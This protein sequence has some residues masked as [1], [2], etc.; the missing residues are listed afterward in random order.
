MPV[1]ASRYV[2]AIAATLL[3]F[4]AHADDA[5]QWSGFALLRAA[6]DSQARPLETEKLS[7]Q[8]QLGV[9]WW[10]TPAF[11]AHVHLVARNDAGSLRGSVGVAEAYVELNVH[12]G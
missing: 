8:M 9:D 1:A 2:A 10:R 5:L 7:A 3:A 6:N 4:S 12:P 11:G